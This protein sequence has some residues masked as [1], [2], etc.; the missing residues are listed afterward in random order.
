MARSPATL[1]AAIGAGCT[2][3]VGH[4]HATIKATPVTVSHAS[5]STQADQQL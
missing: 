5:C 4:M 1:T 2:A 3:A